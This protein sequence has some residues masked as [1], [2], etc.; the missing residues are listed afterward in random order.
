MKK[1]DIIALSEE[2]EAFV[3]ER[4]WDQFHTV[5]NLSIALT[6]EASELMEL[7]QWAKDSEL[8]SLMEDP[9][10]RAQ[11]EDEMADIFFYFFRLVK[12]SKIDLDQAVRAKLQKNADKYPIALVKGRSKKYS[13]Y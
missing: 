4:D 1:P 9:K 3:E 11:F 7:F 8:P 5:K 6:K 10:K 2:I 12:K 13:D